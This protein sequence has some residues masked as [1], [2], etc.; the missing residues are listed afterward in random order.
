MRF[1]AFRQ[2]TTLCGGSLTRQTRR[3]DLP[4]PPPLALAGTRPYDQNSLEVTA[5]LDAWRPV[6]LATVQAWAGTARG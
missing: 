2:N 1:A 4:V 3:R 6:L 5:Y